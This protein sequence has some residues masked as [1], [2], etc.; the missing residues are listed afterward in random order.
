[1]LSI[2]YNNINTG[3][4]P[5]LHDLVVYVSARDLQMKYLPMYSKHST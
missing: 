1:M 5:I 4:T 3:W 2:A